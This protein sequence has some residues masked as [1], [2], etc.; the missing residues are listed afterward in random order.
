[1]TTGEPA[2]DVAAPDV[3]QGMLERSNV[4]PILETRRLIEVQRSYDQA[5]TLIDREDDRIRK[6][7]QVYAA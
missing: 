3:L 7:L 2:E 1:M 6:M 5:R 4:E